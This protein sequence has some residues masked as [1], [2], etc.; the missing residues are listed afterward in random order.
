VQETIAFLPSNKTN[1]AVKVQ[2]SDTSR[3]NFQTVKRRHS[4]CDHT[5]Q[6]NQY[7]ALALPFSH[8]KWP[9]IANK[10]GANPITLC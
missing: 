7:R 5:E 9:M 3:A 10:A 6:E 1:I 4:L 8:F 2:E